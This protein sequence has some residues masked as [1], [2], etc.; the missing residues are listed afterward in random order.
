MP[1]EPY[2]IMMIGRT[3]AGKTTTAAFLA[4]ALQI[5]HILCAK[6]K[7]L[8]VGG[9]YTPRDSLREDLRDIGYK[10]GIEYAQQQLMSGSS[11]ILDASFHKA[12]RRRWVYLALS[13]TCS[14]LVQI[15]CVTSDIEE[16][17]RRILLR[18][19]SEG[20]AR[21]HASD[22]SIFEF[23]DKTFE[24][25]TDGEWDEFSGGVYGFKIDTFSSSL[26]ENPPQD[27]TCA[28]SV[29][30]SIEE[31]LQSLLCSSSRNIS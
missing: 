11:V 3:A 20:S 6:F 14:L 29:L 21:H 17:R 13:G 15:Y 22:F 2:T 24:E 12:K 30:G 31:A 10:K 16:T 23:I 5:E 9:Q 28:I 27:A 19:G 1:H 18:R 7:R 8:A 26:L 4:E 25:P